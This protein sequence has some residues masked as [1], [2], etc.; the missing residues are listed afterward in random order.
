MIDKDIAIKVENISKCYRIGLKEN[1]H[2]TFVESIFDLIKSPLKNYRKYRSLYKFDDINPDQDNN[3]SDIIWALR[4]VSFEV[5]EGEI[6]GIIGLNGPAVFQG[7]VGQTIH[8][9]S[10]CYKTEDE[11]DKGP[12]LVKLDERNQII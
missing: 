3:P 6:V 1:M 10:Y 2:E 9:I 12:L 8:V 5:K 4:D 7:E 11:G